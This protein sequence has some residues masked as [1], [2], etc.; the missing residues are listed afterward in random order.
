MD[1]VYGSP[2]SRC[3]I[4]STVAVQLFPGKVVCGSCLSKLSDT[5]NVE[6]ERIGTVESALWRLRT[7]LHA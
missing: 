3:L 7:L 6:A 5:L 4:P 1:F 2:C